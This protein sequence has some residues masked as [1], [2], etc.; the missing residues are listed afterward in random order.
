MHHV[1]SN[2]WSVLAGQPRVQAK[3]PDQLASRENYQRLEQEDNHQSRAKTGGVGQVHDMCL[4][5]V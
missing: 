3:A 4:L 2:L 1:I 5:A